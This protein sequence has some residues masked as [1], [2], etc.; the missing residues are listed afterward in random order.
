[1]SKNIKK[2]QEMLAGNYKPTIQVSMHGE[3]TPT[4][5]VGDKWTDS[6][7]DQWEQK[8][9]YRSKISK[10][11]GIGIIPHQCKDCNK[12]CDLQKRHKDT[13]MRM[14]RCFHCQLNFE[15]DLKDMR[16][17]HNGN[18]W[19]FWVKLQM[20]KRWETIDQEVQHL[21]FHNSEVKH[22]DKALLNAL[23]NENQRE[24]REKIKSNT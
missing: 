2:I 11:P 12:N 6:E 4:R 21:V 22:N 10:L 9:G 14:G 20:L 1:M 16:I 24:T 17:G 8:N 23:A 13:W 15:L 19:Q 7:G 5:K 3:K 18:K